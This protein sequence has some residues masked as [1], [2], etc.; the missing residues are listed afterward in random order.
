MTGTATKAIIKAT[1]TRNWVALEDKNARELYRKDAN[2]GWTAR[3]STRIN[4]TTS[5]TPRATTKY[6]RMDSPVKMLLCASA[7]E[8]T[9][10][11]P[12]S[13]SAPK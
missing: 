13:A 1:P 11:A 12:P 7:I 4:T 9:V 10:S 2:R 3:L 5:K 8:R 6:G